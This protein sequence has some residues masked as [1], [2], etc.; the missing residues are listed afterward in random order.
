[1]TTSDRQFADSRHRSFCRVAATMRSR[2]SSG[3]G[4]AGQPTDSEPHAGLMGAKEFS[5]FLQQLRNELYSNLAVKAAELEGGTEA[6]AKLFAQLR[7]VPPSFPQ[8]SERD[9]AAIRKVADLVVDQLGLSPKNDILRMAGDKNQSPND[10]VNLT[11]VYA[12]LSDV[13]QRQRAWALN[14]AAHIN[15]ANHDF[16]QS[17]ELS[18]RAL[19][20]ADAVIAADPKLG[21]EMRDLK[22]KAAL[23]AAIASARLGNEAAAYQLQAV[24]IENGSKKAVNL[25]LP[26]SVEIA[27]DLSV[28]R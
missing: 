10:R 9:T 25:S 24:A 16:S 1:L 5:F 14:N 18:K 23:T 15:L 21:I 4:K 6:A 8:L 7:Y 27:R 2:I 20:S 19:A 12:N 28:E 11:L 26:L 17:F 13:A 22:S 3:I